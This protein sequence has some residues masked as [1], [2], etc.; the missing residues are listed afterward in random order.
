M[1]PSLGGVL[2][3]GAKHDDGIFD[4]YYENF[5][6]VSELVDSDSRSSVL[7]LHAW[8]RTIVVYHIGQQ[9]DQN[10]FAL[11]RLGPGRIRGGV[12]SRRDTHDGDKSI[13]NG[14]DFT[15]SRFFQEPATC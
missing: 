3:E 7:N 6:M 9:P 8:G 1:L 11:E 2:D 12:W 10:E 5:K 15:G 13:A 4:F 14:A